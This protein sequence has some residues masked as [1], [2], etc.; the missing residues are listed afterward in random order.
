MFEGRKLL[1][2][3]KHRKEAAIGPILMKALGVGV[4]VEKNFD[5]DQ[6]GTFTGEKERSQ[7]PISTAKQKCKE[8][9]VQSGFDLAIASE[10]SFGPHPTL[11]F[12]PA[13]EEIVVFIDQQNNLELVA[14][15]LS[16]ETNFDA[17]E[18]RT[19]KELLEFANQVMFPS[20][21]L[22]LRPAKDNLQG[23]VKG[24]H[25]ESLLI[26]VFNELKERYATVYVETDMRA[27]HNPSRMKVI[28]KATEK[29]LALINSQCPNCL[30]PGFAASEYIRGLPCSLCG[31][32]TRSVLTEIF[33]CQQ[34]QY[35]QERPNSDNR[36]FEDPM[37]CDFCNP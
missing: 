27:M 16:T 7:D 15:E 35:Q 34:C 19:V 6:L 4:F 22:I 23:M 5:T 17:R 33:T 24:I 25:E 20:H 13:D 9:M 36:D 26:K 3:T 18:V 1:I 21:A 37:Y 32:P 11:F 28:A 14:R 10:G 8:G 2:V 12:M 31:R 30:S 29:L